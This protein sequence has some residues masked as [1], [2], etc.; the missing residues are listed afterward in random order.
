MDI[1]LLLEW[2]DRLLW[3]SEELFILLSE[4]WVKLVSPRTAGP[5]WVLMSGNESASTD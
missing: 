1:V 2:M 5:G 3:S 4:L